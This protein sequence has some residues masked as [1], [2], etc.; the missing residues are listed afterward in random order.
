MRFSTKLWHPNVSSQTGAIC[1]D[2]LGKEWSPALTI[3]TVLLSLQALL[4]SPEPNDPQDAVVAD[5]YKTNYDAF[6]SKARDWTRLF[7]SGREETPGE[8][9]AKLAGFLSCDEKRARKALE[10]HDWDEMLAIS[11]I[12]FEEDMREE[13]PGWGPPR[14]PPG[15]VEGELST[16]PTPM[17]GCGCCQQ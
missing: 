7:A 6:A 9:V 14:A 2:V 5:M 3:R 17:P 1:L 16:S 11:Y 15:P 12:E 4:A 13:G 10:K 8:K